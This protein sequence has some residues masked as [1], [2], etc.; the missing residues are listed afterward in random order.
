MVDGGMLG[1]VYFMNF[2]DCRGIVICGGC[3]RCIF[4]FYKIVHIFKYV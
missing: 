4:L 2:K 3:S 1:V